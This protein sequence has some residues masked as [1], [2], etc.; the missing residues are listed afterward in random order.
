MFCA[1]HSLLRCRPNQSVNWL[2]PPQMASLPCDTSLFTDLLAIHQ[3]CGSND[4]FM[5]SM[6]K[7]R[8]S[9]VI[10]S[11]CCRRAHSKIH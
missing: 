9:G 7:V 2:M 3:E 1:K 4:N 5:H 10:D 8:L 6:R 11:N